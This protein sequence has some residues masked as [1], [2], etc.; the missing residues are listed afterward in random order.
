MLS[1][2]KACNFVV[3]DVSVWGGGVERSRMR[4]AS[5]SRSVYIYG[6]RHY[7]QEYFFP[8]DNGEMETI[9]IMII[10]IAV[11]RVYQ[12]VRS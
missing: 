12:L 9:L 7:L 11:S 3:C 8:E 4:K 5:Q 1:E 10:T 6:P 2:V